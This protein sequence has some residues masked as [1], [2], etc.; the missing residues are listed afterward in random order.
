MTDFERVENALKEAGI[1][2]FDCNSKMVMQGLGVMKVPSLLYYRD[3]V[4]TYFDGEPVAEDIIEWVVESHDLLSTE[5]HDD[6]FEHLTQASSGATTG[7]WLVVLLLNKVNVAWVDINHNPE[8]KERFN[9]KKS[10]EI[11]FD[12]VTEKI[13]EKIKE[14]LASSSS[15]LPLALFGLA[16]VLCILVALLLYFLRGSKAPSKKSN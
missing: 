7:D 10:T 12:K 3:R 6:T 4:P 9:L 2:M 8:L 14:L 1:K 13:A 16:A 15:G 11:M 5:L